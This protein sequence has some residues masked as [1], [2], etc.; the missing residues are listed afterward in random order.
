MKPNCLSRQDKIFGQMGQ[1]L[2]A[3]MLLLALS[4]SGA[5]HGDEVPV[6]M[7]TLIAKPSTAFAPL[8]WS[9]SSSWQIP[10]GKAAN[11]VPSSTDIVQIPANAV[12]QINA[13]TPTAQ[14]VDIS[15]TLLFATTN[16]AKLKLTAQ[17]IVVE[18]GGTFTIGRNIGPIPATSTVT[19]VLGGGTPVGVEG[20]LIDQG[21]LIIGNFAA[22]GTAKSGYA[23]A[24][25][26]SPQ[27]VTLTAPVTNWQVGDR[28]ALPDTRSP[29][30]RYVESLG[31][32]GIAGTADD[33]LALQQ[34]HSEV[35]TIA[36]VSADRQLVT[37]K[38]PALY[39]H[40]NPNGG[41]FH[42]GNLSRNVTITTNATDTAKRGHII[43]LDPVGA[44]RA[45]TWTGNSA[46]V[47]VKNVAFAQLGRTTAAPLNA[48]TNHI[49]RYAL[50]FHH[51][52]G[53]YKA[54]VPV[55][56]DHPLYP[57]GRN[58]ADKASVGGYRMSVVNCAF[59]NDPT[60]PNAL[61]N[62]TKWQIAIHG[63]CG[64]N[65]AQNVF[66]G[67]QG[68]AL[69]TEDGSEGWNDIVGNVAMNCPGGAK[70]ALPDPPGICS[71]TPA[72]DTVL[73]NEGVGFWLSNAS[74]NVSNNVAADCRLAGILVYPHLKY[75]PD[76]DHTFDGRSTMGIAPPYPQTPIARAATEFRSLLDTNL[77]WNVLLYPTALQNNEV[78]ACYDGIELW[79]TERTRVAN[80]VARNC[81]IG[82]MC[83]YTDLVTIDGAM[84]RG[85][86]IEGQPTLLLGAKYVAGNV[87]LPEPI[88]ADTN[89]GHWEIE[90]TLNPPEISVPPLPT[91]GIDC[92]YNQPPRLL[93]NIDV[94]ACW[95]GVRLATPRGQ[96]GGTL[97]LYPN[98][99][100]GGP[101]SLLTRNT[102]IQDS[103]FACVVG[104][105]INADQHYK[106]W[107]YGPA[108]TYI[109]RCSFNGQ[110]GYT[111]S[112]CKAVWPVLGSDWF[113]QVVN[114]P[115]SN[116]NHWW[117]DQ[118]ACGR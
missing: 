18:V 82:I 104:V 14:V 69:M 94:S 65:I 97:P 56:A 55:A 45:T 28:L 68:A 41:T 21:L 107:S 113:L 96:G 76:G 101:M 109:R 80:T 44:E 11:R 25:S 12:V 117:P 57:Y 90:P 43:V 99:V 37:F 4:K 93:N 15:G 30:R 40:N 47:N 115:F 98:D 114:Q 33:N 78:Y 95:M 35:V 9:S 46:S 79:K 116:W 51:T 62:N 7:P 61:A 27:M 29:R 83:R 48:V 72:E 6:Y 52:I 19:V 100:V 112:P 106:R 22:F 34:S 26:F 38:T 118:C 36:S 74:N 75:N 70:N 3:M 64:I 16:K 54:V 111:N 10:G 88:N 5:A 53:N 58:P 59:E 81:Q 49:G 103:S 84:V 66:Y 105:Y 2:C 85:E 50:H 102:T 17:T 92:G 67:A 71:L 8:N 87:R 110:P 86:Q 77:D 108:K 13:A 60:M 31:A 1:M 89:E 32:D 24:A 63:S 42:I 39:E 73:G 23:R 20:N 91:I